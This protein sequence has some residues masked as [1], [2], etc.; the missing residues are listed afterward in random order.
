MLCQNIGLLLAAGISSRFNYDKPKQLYKINDIPIIMYSVNA[1]IN[2]V[3]ILI[4][5]TNST[6]YAEIKNLVQ[7]YEKVVV[8]VND[9]NCRL[10]SI[11][12]GLRYIKNSYD[13]YNNS[14]RRMHIEPTQDTLQIIIHDAARPFI[15]ENH[16]K[17]L[18]NNLNDKCLYSQYYLKLV[19]GLYNAKSKEMVNR[20]D[21]IEI[22]TPLVSDFDLYYSIFMKYINN[23][24]R[25]AYEHISVMDKYKYKYKLVEGNNSYLRKI[26]YY[27]DII[28]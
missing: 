23:P 8:L 24:C 15:N 10:E 25:I 9:V 14:L 22:C 6:C 21:Y 3:S 12:I 7:D 19:N 11:A 18:L 28:Y 16:I 26:T 20:D 17:D 13:L 4:I 2:I 5:I 27:D 1:L